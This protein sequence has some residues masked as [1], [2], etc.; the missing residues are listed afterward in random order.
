MR[1]KSGEFEIA[2]G[3]LVIRCPEVGKYPEELRAVIEAA[4]R[5]GGKYGGEQLLVEDGTSSLP[6]VLFNTQGDTAK[7]LT[8]AQKEWLAEEKARAARPHPFINAVADG[9]CLDC[10]HHKD[11]ELHVGDRQGRLVDAAARVRAIAVHECALAQQEFDEDELMHT[12]VMT[13]IND[14]VDA[15]LMAE[16]DEH[17]EMVTSAMAKLSAKIDHL[18]KTRAS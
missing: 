15:G 1:P 9:D 17:V 8:D 2:M 18:R 5:D 6:K 10:G 11:H 4:Y 16:D 14:Y 12:V 13:W 7:P 3:R